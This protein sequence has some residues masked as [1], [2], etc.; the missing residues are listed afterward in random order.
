[1]GIVLYVFKVEKSIPGSLFWDLT[2]FGSIFGWFY[3]NLGHFLMFLQFFQCFNKGIMGVKLHV[4]EV[5]KSNR[6]VLFEIWPLVIAL[7]APFTSVRVFQLFTQR[8]GSWV[9]KYMF[10]RSLSTFSGSF[11]L[12]Q[13]FFTIFFA[14]YYFQRSNLNYSPKVS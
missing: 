9:A 10:S 4:F 7:L 12:I 8:L 13:P 6:I 11:F 14:P 3:V 2:T 5:K 1:M